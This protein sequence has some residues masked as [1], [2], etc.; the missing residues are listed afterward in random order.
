MQTGT[1]PN[2]TKPM[3]ILPSPSLPNL[4]VQRLNMLNK[5]STLK[6]SC[7]GLDATPETTDQRNEQAHEQSS[8]LERRTVDTKHISTVSSLV[9]N[10]TEVDEFG[11]KTGKE[12]Q[13]NNFG[14][15]ALKF[16]RNV[17]NHA[18]NMLMNFKK[19][20]NGNHKRTKSIKASGS[21]DIDESPKFKQVTSNRSKH[22]YFEPCH[23]PN[24]T[25]D[26][27][28]QYESEHEDGGS[29]DIWNNSKRFQRNRF[30]LHSDDTPAGA[31]VTMMASNRPS[32]R[33]PVRPR[34]IKPIAPKA[35]TNS[36]HDAN[37]TK[38]TYNANHQYYEN[39]Q[40]IDNFGSDQ[41]VMNI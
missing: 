7:I 10:K 9:V 6:G 37:A 3:K 28:N 23:Q 17:A 22:E 16:H 36:A 34:R 33:M 32:T 25:A 21:V 15:Y 20:N 2:A 14:L 31:T 11:K 41:N 39:T 27:R 30:I 12:S 13:R 1:F 18:N 19:D 29:V 40:S 5:L 24:C 8:D 35:N 4:K 38:N 26:Q